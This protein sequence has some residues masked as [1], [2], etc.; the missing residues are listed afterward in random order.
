MYKDIVNINE[1]ILGHRHKMEQA[2]NPNVYGVKIKER[3]EQNAELIKS[4]ESMLTVS[5]REVS[6]LDFIEEIHLELGTR[7]D[8]SLEILIKLKNGR[9][10]TP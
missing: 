9:W 6:N 7:T 1:K 5:F 10:A 4:T 3:R 2:L 8:A